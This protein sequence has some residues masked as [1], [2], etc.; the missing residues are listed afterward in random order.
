MLQ[1]LGFQVLTACNGREALDVFGRNQDKI[2]CVL[3]DLTMPCM[4]GEQTYRELRRL[5][6]ALRVIIS[7]G[8]NEREVTQKFAG[9]GLAGFIQ[10]PYTVA[11][12]SRKLREVFG[13]Q[14]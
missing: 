5:N 1:A 12:M 8:Y 4:D 14:A 7:S 11:E 3:L 2:V 6:P 9:A 13:V 10:K